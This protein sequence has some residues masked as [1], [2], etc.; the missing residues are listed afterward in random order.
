MVNVW[1]KAILILAG[2]LNSSRSYLFT[3]VYENQSAPKKEQ[4]L[5]WNYQFL[6]QSCMKGS[7]IGA[8][9]FLGVIISGS[10]L[11]NLHQIKP[12]AQAP[13]QMHIIGEASCF[14]WQ[15]FQKEFRSEFRL[16]SSTRVLTLSKNKVEGRLFIQVK[17]PAE[18]ADGIGII[19]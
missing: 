15:E 16:E 14:F 2:N 19:E 10:G 18:E 3:A 5:I 17:I 7:I 12:F 6:F 11:S 1:E 9:Y 4:I 13:N 8:A